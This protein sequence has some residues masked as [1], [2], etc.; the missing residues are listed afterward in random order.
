MG[1]RLLTLKSV[2]D[3]NGTIHCNGNSSGWLHNRFC[4]NGTD[5][6]D[7]DC[8]YFTEQA[9]KGEIRLRAGIPGL[10]SGVFLGKGTEN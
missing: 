6:D 7:P 8:K 10:S 3:E 1:E 2:K 9:E 4:G 5:P